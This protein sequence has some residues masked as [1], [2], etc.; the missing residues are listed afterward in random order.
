MA[1]E[2]QDKTAHSPITM[3]DAGAGTSRSGPVLRASPELDETTFMTSRH[4]LLT[5]L[6]LPTT[7]R[8]RLLTPL[9]RM[10][11]GVGTWRRLFFPA[12]ETRP[13]QAAFEGYVASAFSSKFPLRL[14][15]H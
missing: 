2:A 10:Q 11:A 13:L 4:E 5:S 8:P 9:V 7:P 14:P 3:R 12:L 6:L 1:G 15:P